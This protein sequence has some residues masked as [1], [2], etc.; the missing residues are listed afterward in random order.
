MQPQKDIY[1]TADEQ[2]LTNRKLAAENA[3][4]KE[5]L[6]RMQN[7]LQQQQNL[8][9][10]ISHQLR[11]PLSA[12]LGYGDMLSEQ[13]SA[14]EGAAKLNALLAAA[15]TLAA[16]L[17]DMPQTAYRESEPQAAPCNPA[18][19]MAQIEGFFSY[20]AQHKNLDFSCHWD[21]AIPASLYADITML[22]QVL[23][24]LVHNALKFTE[25]G[26]VSLRVSLQQI[27]DY[28][29]Q[30]AFRVE[31][32]GR[33]IAEEKL[34]RLFNPQKPAQ[35]PRFGRAG[36]SLPLAATLLRAMGA[37]L[38]VASTLGKGSC[39]SFLL[40]LSIH[41]PREIT[42]TADTGTMP[43]AR[44]QQKRILVVDDHPM[45][46]SLLA[47]MVQQLGIGAVDSAADGEEALSLLHSQPYDMVLMDC[48]MPHMD[49]F[50]TTRRMRQA[51]A[52]SAIPVIGITA[53]V[54]TSDAAKCYAAGMDD[55]YHK[56]VSR[57][58]LEHIL[59]K[60]LGE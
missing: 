42:D 48:H 13:L 55:Y 3:H 60:W 27:S 39:F 30:L 53:D 5:A 21:A 1:T 9:G 29:A 49:G 52:T 26:A 7:R 36:N 2:A 24:I 19:L 34:P 16:V 6:Q 38:E 12:I 51:S 17:N 18:A 56:P 15:N 37:Q 28:E 8:L 50:V 14:G 23:L 45:N 40:A 11:T 41:H 35:S 57:A 59:H 10:Q 47:T 33:G 46:R 20:E 4:Y 58:A 25:S 32:S 31:D 22:R 54:M 44:W 43:V